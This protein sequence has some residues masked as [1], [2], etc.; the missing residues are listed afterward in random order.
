ML[1]PIAEDVPPAFL[2]TLLR[3]LSSEYT[4]KQECGECICLLFEVKEKHKLIAS[5]S[6]ITS[7]E[8]AGELFSLHPHIV[9]SIIIKLHKPVKCTRT[10]S[11]ATWARVVAFPRRFPKEILFKMCLFNNL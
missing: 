8:G 11:P 9:S 10:V 6:H 5:L 7:E 1:S 3:V 2:I 4:S